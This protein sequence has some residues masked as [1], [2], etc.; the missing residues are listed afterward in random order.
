MRQQGHERL[1]SENRPS[2]SI[3]ST[4]KVAETRKRPLDNISEDAETATGTGV[5]RDESRIDSAGPSR[6]DVF[7]ASVGPIAHEHGGPKT[8]ATARTLNGRNAVEQLDGGNAV[9]AI[10]RRSSDDQRDA[11]G[12]GDQVALAGIFPSVRR[13]GTRVVPPK[14]ERID[15]LST[16]AKHMSTLPRMPSWLSRS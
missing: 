4:G 5:Y 16:G 13:F 14:T 15:A 6:R 1:G 8:G 11:R 7:G 10:G 3:V 12:I 9:V 2:R